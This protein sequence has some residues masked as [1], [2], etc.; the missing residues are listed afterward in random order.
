MHHVCMC[1][2]VMPIAPA[3]QVCG[4][5]GTLRE[6]AYHFQ[7]ICDRCMDEATIC[8]MMHQPTV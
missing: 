7:F 6:F 4:K 1:A 5:H 8:C 2:C 3:A